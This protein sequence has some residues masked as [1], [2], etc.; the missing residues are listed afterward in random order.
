MKEVF[1]EAL[2]E[3]KIFV[4]LKLELINE[5]EKYEIRTHPTFPTACWRWDEKEK[6]NKILIGEKVVEGV[7]ENP[8]DYVLSFGYHE[9][10]HSLFT[11]RMGVPE[12]I[13]KEGIPFALFNLFED[14]R[15]EEL[16]R[17][18]YKRRFEWMKWEREKIKKA[19][20]EWTKY[21]KENPQKIE[22][23]K[24]EGVLKG[25]PP[26]AHP[27]QM[28]LFLIQSEG[29]LE[30]EGNELMERIREYYE[31]TITIRDWRETIEIMKEWVREFPIEDENGNPIPIPQLIPSSEGDGGKERCELS[32]EGEEFEELWEESEKEGGKEGE[33]ES[34][35]EKNDME[36]F[37]ESEG[38]NVLREE[39]LVELDWERVREE[40][41]RIIKSFK[42]LSR[43][44]NTSTPSKRL[45]KRFFED[46]DEIYLREQE[47]EIR[48]RPFTILIDCSGSM[49]Q[50]VPEQHYLAGIFSEIVRKTKT[51]GYLILTETNREQLFKLP[52]PEEIVE[53]IP[54]YGRTENILGGL[55][56]FERYILK[57][58]LLFIV[59]DME[60]TDYWRKTQEKI[61]E[62]RRKGVE[63][64][65]IYKGRYYEDARENAP[66]FFDKFVATK[67]SN[68]VDL[69]IPLLRSLRRSG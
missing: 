23:W 2:R 58:K 59:S 57:T 41:Q 44:T 33:K 5:N 63:V 46:R 19:L 17:Q 22:E 7:K 36:E 31:K 14:A 69:L 47:I 3:L 66:Q 6:K 18:Q 52:V 12:E 62:L 40:A 55:R 50:M 28:F 10:A 34:I 64:I 20:K 1:K 49:L 27:N 32:V 56:R 21:Y 68:P 45:T 35:G 4:F 38:D 15:I 65:G 67:D 24:K 26:Q 8:K 30:V 51:D 53:R 42:T 16:F 11:P 37:V 25:V 9:I 54:F 48:I 39:R 43:K 61:H 13:G 60:I 29:E